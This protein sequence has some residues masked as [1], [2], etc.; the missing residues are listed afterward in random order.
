MGEEFI[1][2]ESCELLVSMDEFQSRRQISRHLSVRFDGFK[3]YRRLVSLY[4]FCGFIEFLEMDNMDQ[5]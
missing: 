1:A 3:F 2:R 4:R 5:L